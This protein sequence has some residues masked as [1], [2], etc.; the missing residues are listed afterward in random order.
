M[1]IAWSL[2]Q[3]R[4]AAR[5][6]KAIIKL[7]EAG[8]VKEIRAKAGAP[9]WRRDEERSRAHLCA[10][11]DRGRR[12]GKPSTGLSHEAEVGVKWKVQRG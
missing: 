11:A 9:I 4:S 10:Q 3:V 12:K 7:L 8:I 6:E 5:P 1:I 2:R